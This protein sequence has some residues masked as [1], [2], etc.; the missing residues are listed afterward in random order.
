MLTYQYEC[1]ICNLDVEVEEYQLHDIHVEYG[2]CFNC[3]YK[4]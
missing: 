2:Q 4:N 1:K 3:F